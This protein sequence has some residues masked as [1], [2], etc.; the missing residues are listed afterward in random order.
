MGNYLA[1]GIRPARVSGKK[2]EIIKGLQWSKC[3]IFIYKGV[4][5]KAIIVINV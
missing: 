4:T 5:M 3:M 2:E 1:R